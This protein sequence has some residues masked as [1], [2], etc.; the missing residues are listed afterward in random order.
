MIASDFDRLE[1]NIKFFIMRMQEKYQEDKYTTNQSKS[2]NALEPQ[3]LDEEETSDVSSLDDLG[4]EEMGLAE[5][6]F[7]KSPTKPLS[8]QGTPNTF[9]VASEVQIQ[10]AAPSDFISQLGV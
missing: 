6:L 8:T 3:H 10:Q 1:E 4:G 7:S 5:K 9:K 2:R